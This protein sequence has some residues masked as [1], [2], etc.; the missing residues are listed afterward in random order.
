MIVTRTEFVRRCGWRELLRHVFKVYDFRRR[1]GGDSRLIAL[2]DA[3]RYGGR[4]V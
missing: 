3:I 1:H 4:I 2:R